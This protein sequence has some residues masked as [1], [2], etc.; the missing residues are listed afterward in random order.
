MTRTMIR[1]KGENGK[2]RGL[3]EKENP[4]TKMN[5]RKLLQYCW[6]GTNKRIKRNKGTMRNYNSTQS[7]TA[8]KFP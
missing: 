7:I 1:R 5:D 4:A 8:A 2:M 6:I 3:S